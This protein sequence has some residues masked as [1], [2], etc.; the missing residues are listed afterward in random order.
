[1]SRLV[2]PALWMMLAQLLGDHDHVVAAIDRVVQLVGAHFRGERLQDLLRVGRPFIHDLARR[3]GGHH[4]D[5]RGALGH[6]AYDGQR[7]PCGVLL[8]LGEAIGKFAGM[9]ERRAVDAAGRT[10]IRLISASRMA[11]PMTEVARSLLPSALNVGLAPISRRIGPLM[12]TRMAH[13]PV[14]EV[15]PCRRNSSFSMACQ[16]VA[17]T[18][19]CIGRQPAMT[20]LM[21]SFSAVMGCSRTGSMPMQLIRRHHRPVEAGRDR[22]FR[23]RHHRQA[24]GPAVAVIEFL[25]GGEIVDIVDLRGQGRLDQLLHNIICDAQFRGAEAQPARRRWASRFDRCPSADSARRYSP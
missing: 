12:M 5:G 24:V 22:G 7:L 20:A 2:Q 17:T 3:H 21:A 13:P 15:T 8:V 14:L 11:R 16:A 1:M 23:R 19:K 25:S 10:S 4:G 9:A 18:G 6:A